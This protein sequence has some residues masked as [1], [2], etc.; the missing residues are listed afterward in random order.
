MLE[1][2]V[3]IAQYGKDPDQRVILTPSFASATNLIEAIYLKKT[4]RI[5]WES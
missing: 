3:S 2:L 5:P 1:S 4:D